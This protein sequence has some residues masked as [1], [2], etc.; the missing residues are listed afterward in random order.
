MTY[1]QIQ[2]YPVGTKYNIQTKTFLI[3]GHWHTEH[4]KDLILHQNKYTDL[5]F[6]DNNLFCAHEANIFYNQI[7]GWLFN[8]REWHCVELTCNGYQEINDEDILK[9]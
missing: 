6:M 1:Q 2:N 8:G 5:Q 9:F 7:D 3:T 4:D